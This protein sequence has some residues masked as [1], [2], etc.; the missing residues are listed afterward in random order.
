MRRRPRGE[1][2]IRL[3]GVG[4][5]YGL[6]PEVLQDISFALPAGS[7]HFLTGPSGAGKSSLL[8][9]MYLGLRPTRGRV[10]LFDRDIAQTKRYEL[11]A[12]RRRI[13]VVFQDFRLLDH[14]SAL[15]NVALPL[16]VRGVKESEVQKHVPELLGWVGLADHLNAKPSTLSGG[17]K[18]RVAIARAVIGRPDLLL[19]DEPTGNVDDH[20]AMR[21]LHLF[22]ELNKLGTT[23]VIATHNEGLVQRFAHHKRLHLEHGTVSKV[24]E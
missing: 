14:L 22:E 8:R 21:L 6:G 20:I 10:M 1:H 9:L 19:A 23:I 2:I 15:D 7:F 18:Q 4:L 11:P 12:L 5:R 13:G 16:R 17:Q 24:E 3:D